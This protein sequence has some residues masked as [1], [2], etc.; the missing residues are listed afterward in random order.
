MP[1]YANNAKHPGSSDEEMSFGTDDEM[2]A[3]AYDD[4]AVTAPPKRAKKSAKAAPKAPSA[5]LADV[6]RQRKKAASDN[7]KVEPGCKDEEEEDEEALTQQPAKK[8]AAAKKKP[9]A[10]AVARKRAARPKA[11]AAAVGDSGKEEAGAGKKKKVAKEKR[12]LNKFQLFNQTVRKI[13]NEQNLPGW[14]DPSDKNPEN[15]K[16]QAKHIFKITGMCWTCGGGAA[17]TAA[18]YVEVFIRT[19]VYISSPAGRA[20]LAALR[21]T[22]ADTKFPVAH[23]EMLE[24][25]ERIL[26]VYPALT[27]A[28]FGS[29]AM[30]AAEIVEVF[31]RRHTEITASIEAESSASKRAITEA[32]EA[33][34]AEA[35]KTMKIDASMFDVSAVQEPQQPQP[36]PPPAAA[37]PQADPI[38]PAD[39]A[40]A[41]ASATEPSQTTLA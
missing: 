34:A 39:Q 29:E 40:C 20:Q 26:K 9:S 6:Q 10:P 25:I 33:K 31:E 19:M 36:A 3:A 32:A 17:A 35:I 41:P 2:A 14:H 7:R 22:P 8:R 21:G 11:V 38:V 28:P 16:F 27:S 23:I 4:D 37:H 24:Y 30:R 15:V 13:L 12:P 1:K 18:R 5:K